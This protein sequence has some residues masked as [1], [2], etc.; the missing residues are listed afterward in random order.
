VTFGIKPQT[1]EAESNQL[2]VEN[3]DEVFSSMLKTYQI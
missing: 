2:Y 3:V 1:L